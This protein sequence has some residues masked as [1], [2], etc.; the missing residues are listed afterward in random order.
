MQTDAWLST[1]AASFAAARLHVL[2]ARYGPNHS[3][4]FSLHEAVTARPRGAARL[5]V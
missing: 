4:G 3:G 1:T 5:R 2:H